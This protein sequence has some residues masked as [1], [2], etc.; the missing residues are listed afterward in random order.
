MAGAR[1][2]AKSSLTKKKA[3][4][5]HKTT[6]AHSKAKKPGV[7]VSK[8]LA[9][10]L[11]QSG[12]GSEFFV[13]RRASGAI[14]TTARGRLVVER[15]H[16]KRRL[17]LEAIEDHN[18]LESPEYVA[19]SAFEPDARA[20][21]LLRGRKIVEGDLR[22]SG[23]AYSMEEVRALLG[24][25]SRQ[26]VHKKAAQ[27]DLLS[28]TGP[29]RRRMFPTIQFTREGLT[30]GLRAVAAAF[31]SKNSWALLNFL[32]NPDDR[33]AGRKPIELLR[34]GET[35]LVVEAARGTGLQGA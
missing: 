34:A 35:D 29:G 5:A 13:I 26:T 30:P 23:G 9:R 2:Y 3:K 17:L 4:P 11:H 1:R 25:V 21:A 12:A 18:E 6:V 16:A 24:H 7:A 19:E 8:A 32:A 22:A 33:L 14:E 31:P 20:Q 10:A 15:L 28:V 27:G